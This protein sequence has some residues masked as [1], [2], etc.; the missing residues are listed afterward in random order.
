MTSLKICL[1]A[2]G[3]GHVRQLFDLLPAVAGHKCFYMT[4]PTAL[5]QSINSDFPTFFVS[6]VALGQAKLG[7]PWKMVMS[8]VR[9]CW[10]SFSIIRRERPDLVIS[11]GAGSMAF[12][13]LWGRMFGAKLVLIDSF[14]RF[15]APSAFAR[16]VG[17]VAHVRIAQSQAAAAGRADIRVFDPFRLVSSPRPSKKDMMFATVGATLP[18]DRLVDMVADAQSRG[19]TPAKVIVQ[20]GEGGRQPA[21]LDTVETMP[22]DQIQ[23]TLK[24]ADIVVCH[25]GTGSLITALQAG[26]HVIAV[27][28]LYARREHYDDHQ[29][30]IA[31]AL[32][33][34]GL[35]QIAHNQS[36]FDA[37][38]AAI[39]TRE[40]VM[41]TT[42]PQ[43]LMAFLRQII[44]GILAARAGKPGS[45]G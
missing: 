45:M 4:E 25:A 43:A 31:E 44:A 8:G 37:A 24:A 22:F 38:L 21:D 9:N 34:R 17:P 41:A 16:I 18:F 30:E 15:H 13:M 35:V 33:A 28:R 7:A 19:L 39:R 23:E 40:A 36:E 1:A 2:S 32:A 42:D 6:H 29:S 26:C 10:Q 3:G 27:P 11:T 5:G 12:A 20:V 14:A